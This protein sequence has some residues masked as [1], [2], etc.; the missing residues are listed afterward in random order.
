[1]R[2]HLC[3]QGLLRFEVRVEGAVSKAGG[4]SDL[5]DT[6]LVEAALAEQPACGF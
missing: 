5:G 1:M 3:A 4:G 6:D 2:D